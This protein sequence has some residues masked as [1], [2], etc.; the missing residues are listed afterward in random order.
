MD[1]E[2][3]VAS[4]FTTCKGLAMKWEQRCQC[5]SLPLHRKSPQ[6][7]PFLSRPRPNV[8]QGLEKLKVAPLHQGVGN[9]YY[10]S[11][12]S[13]QSIWRLISQY[14]EVTLFRDLAFYM[15]HILSLKQRTAETKQGKCG[16]GAGIHSTSITEGLHARLGMRVQQYKRQKKPTWMSK[17]IVGQ[18][19]M[20]E[21]K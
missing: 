5:E 20:T 2:G 9:T 12:S 8:L 10:W 14:Q 19:A 18:S 21:K 11:I 1:L 13:A 15:V 7:V 6:N 4:P 3:S 17:R 16:D